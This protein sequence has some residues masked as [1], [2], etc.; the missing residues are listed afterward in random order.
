VVL[1]V[2]AARPVT[3]EIVGGMSSFFLV[4]L[5]DGEADEEQVGVRGIEG[6][7]GTWLSAVACFELN[8]L[9]VAHWELDDLC[10]VR[11]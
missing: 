8:D 11:T 10:V 4:V 9:P 5:V 2:Y 6:E 3:V 7:D 1:V